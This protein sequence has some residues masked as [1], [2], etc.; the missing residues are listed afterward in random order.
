MRKL[1]EIGKFYDWTPMKKHWKLEYRK[2][3]N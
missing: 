2:Q 1:P 3:L